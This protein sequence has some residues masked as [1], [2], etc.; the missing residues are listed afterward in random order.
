MLTIYKKPHCMKLTDILKELD[1]QKGQLIKEASIPKDMKK[2]EH[3]DVING[4][5]F[6]LVDK[7][8]K[9]F[10]ATTEGEDHEVFWTTGQANRELLRAIGEDQFIKQLADI[11]NIVVKEVM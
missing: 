10:G 7:S 11:Y 5:Q 2:Q 4:D 8:G 9:K 6:M 3:H 1:S